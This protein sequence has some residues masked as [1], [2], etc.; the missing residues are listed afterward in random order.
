M[1]TCLVILIRVISPPQTLFYFLYFVAM[2]KR[3]RKPLSEYTTQYRIYADAFHHLLRYIHE[4]NIHQLYTKGK[5]AFGIQEKDVLLSYNINGVLIESKLAIDLCDRRHCD[6]L[7]RAIQDFFIDTWYLYERDGSTTKN[8]DLARIHG[9][10]PQAMKVTLQNI[11]DKLKQQ[12][13]LLWGN[14]RYS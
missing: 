2:Q 3:W 9:I 6:E 5:I 10:S 12:S 11:K 7:H 14:P 4:K 1:E 8:Q 13:H